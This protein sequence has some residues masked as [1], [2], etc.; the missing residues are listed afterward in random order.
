MWELAASF[1]GSTDAELSMVLKAV[2]LGPL[3]Y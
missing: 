1:P 2:V 3:P